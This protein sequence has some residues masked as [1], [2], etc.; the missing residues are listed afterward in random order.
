MSKS[1]CMFC[2]KNADTKEHVIPQWMH[3]Y[4]NIKHGKLR[5]RNGTQI[6]YIHEVVPACRRCNE[7]RFSR[8]EQR[9]KSQTALPQELYVWALKIYRGLNLKDSFL[10]ESRQDPSRGNILTHEESLK[11]IEFSTT[12]LANYGKPGF[13]LYPNPFGSVFEIDLPREI[14]GGFSLCSIGLPYNVITISLTE[15]RLLTVI[16]NDKGLTHRAIKMGLLQYHWAV[17]FAAAAFMNE[18][19][20]AIN[21]NTY[22]KFVTLHYC[23]SKCRISIPKGQICRQNRVAAIRLPSKI[24]VKTEEDP[25]LIADLM[26]KLF[27]FG[28]Q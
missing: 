9:V 27:D 21:A 16:L 23:R 18:S 14:E 11:G 19:D 24:R 10:P 2:G 22:A 28:G 26:R 3:N 15:T 25:L 6:K 13:T 5:L 17:N 7:V 8:I 4:Y 12:I 20:P 1:L